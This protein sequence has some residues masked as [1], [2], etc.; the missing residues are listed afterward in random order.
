MIY[1]V[2]KVRTEIFITRG[3]WQFNPSKE[4][5]ENPLILNLSTLHHVMLSNELWILDIKDMGIEKLL[6]MH[7]K[8]AQAIFHLEDLRSA[9]RDAF[10]GAEFIHCLRRSFSH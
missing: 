1:Y 10:E 8:K 4:R 9:L 5:R 7:E 6:L 3:F 2:E